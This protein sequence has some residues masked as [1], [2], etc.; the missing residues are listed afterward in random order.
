MTRISLVLMFVLCCPPLP[1]LAAQTASAPPTPSPAGRCVGEARA[2]ATSALE[3]GASREAARLQ[4]EIEA[5]SC[6]DPSLTPAA[7]HLIGTVNADRAR[8]ARDFLAGKLTINGYRAVTR[9]AFARM[10]VDTDGFVVEYQMS[11]RAMKLGLRVV[12]IPTHEGDRI[13][14]RST[15][16]S[17]PTGLVFLRFLIRELRIGSPSP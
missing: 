9:Q 14:G 10:G 3:K 2:R 6:F 15:A 11:I 1:R 8:F 12:E 7:A 17:L 5:A 16:K 4:L 13:G